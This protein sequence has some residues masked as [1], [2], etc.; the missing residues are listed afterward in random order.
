MLCAI[1]R[2]VP[3]TGA[4]VVVG[5]AIAG[6]YREHHAVGA[7]KITELEIAGVGRQ[8]HGA[9]E[10]VGTVAV[11]GDLLGQRLQQLDAA[12]DPRLDVAAGQAAEILHGGLGA[13]VQALALTIV[14]EQDETGECNG[15]HEGGSQQD[16]MAEFHVSGH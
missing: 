4:R 9:L 16:F 5:G 6:R 7:T 3:A 10:A 8:A 14:V 12:V 11:H 15:H 2:L 1:G 13:G